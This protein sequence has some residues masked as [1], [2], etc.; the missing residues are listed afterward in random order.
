MTE[1]QARVEYT[2]GNWQK[3]DRKKHTHRER[4]RESAIG[5]LYREVGRAGEG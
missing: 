1:I 3:R 5:W 4:E 2:A